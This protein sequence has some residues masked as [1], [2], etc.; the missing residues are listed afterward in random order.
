MS[1]KLWSLTLRQGWRLTS[2]FFPSL[3]LIYDRFMQVE[4]TLPE[5]AQG[6]FNHGAGVT[7]HPSRVY[8]GG[9]RT[10]HTH[11]APVQ[12]PTDRLAA[13]LNVTVSWGTSYDL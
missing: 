7:G 11:R 12:C 10:V 9:Y 2:L 13:A 6:L 1:A 5:Q 4:G 8:I 3:V